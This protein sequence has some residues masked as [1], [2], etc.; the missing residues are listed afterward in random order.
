MF[1]VPDSCIGELKSTYHIF[2]VF[3]YDALMK[4]VEATETCG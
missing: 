2:F 4:V 1:Y 3:L